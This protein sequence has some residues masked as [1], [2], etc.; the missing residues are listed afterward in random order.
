MLLHLCFSL[1]GAQLA[2]V[3]GIRASETSS[4][5]CVIV[6]MSLHFFLLV[7]FMWMLGEALTLH[8]KLVK[9]LPGNITPDNIY[10]KWVKI[11]WLL[12]LFIVLVTYASNQEDYTTEHYCWMD[13]TQSIIVSFLLPLFLVMFFNIMEFFLIVITLKKLQGKEVAWKASL[14]FFSIL[15]VTW[16]LAGAVAV[17]PTLASQ[18]LFAFANTLQGAF[19]FYYH[20]WKSQVI[21]RYWKESVG[22]HVDSNLSSQG[23]RAT[24]YG[25]AACRSS[26]QTTSTYRSSN[27]TTSIYRTTLTSGQTNR[28]SGSY[29]CSQ[30]PKYS[31]VAMDRYSS[32]DQY[33]SVDATTVVSED[34]TY[35]TANSETTL[36][37]YSIPNKDKDLRKSEGD[38]LNEIV[39]GSPQFDVDRVGMP[40]IITEDDDEEEENAGRTSRH[41]TL[42]RLHQ[43]LGAGKDDDTDSIDLN[44]L[45]IQGRSRSK[46]YSHTK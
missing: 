40:E 24:N 33:L 22:M 27:Q 14:T 19:I 12:P 11:A 38:V 18:F 23:T 3:S 30:A 2:F 39:S 46:K 29:D 31:S 15:G 37:L 45:E 32:I 20:C 36:P 44:Y 5:G 21:M 6:S 28:K 43:A 4:G 26:N 7:S 10:N 9:I 42:H 34:T 25:G 16:G 13:T 1:F 17:D 8:L 41:S 35:D